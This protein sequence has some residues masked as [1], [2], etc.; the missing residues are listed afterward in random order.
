M[1]R[2]EANNTAKSPRKNID[3][4]ELVAKNVG[5]RSVLKNSN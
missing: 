3:I 1:L 5:L 4:D 2:P